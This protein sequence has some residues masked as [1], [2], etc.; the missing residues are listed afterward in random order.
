MCLD[1]RDAYI[2]V[3]IHLTG[4][5]IHN[6]NSLITD[7]GSDLHEHDSQKLAFVGRK[8]LEMFE[9]VSRYCFKIIYCLEYV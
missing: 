1:V 3:H 7:N 2:R 5:N 9:N 6:K 4:S 8:S